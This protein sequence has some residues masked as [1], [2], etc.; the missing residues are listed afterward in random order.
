MTNA[1][2]TFERAE[3]YL[4]GLI[5]ERDSQRKSLG[6][7]RIRALLRALGDPHRSYPSVHVG[8]TSG[9]GSTATMIA[10]ALSAS[11]KRTGLH[12]KPHLHSM[13]ERAAIDGVSIERDRFGALLEE[14]LPAVERVT[15]AHGK[16]TYYETL[17]ALAFLYFAREGVDA[18]VIEVGLGGRL[19][20]TNVLLP[21]V[22]VI[23]S[24]GL[25]HTEVLG[26]TIEQ[27]AAEKAGIAK[28]GIPLVL[29]VEREEA[30]AVIE[31][32]AR[33]VGAPVIHAAR[34][35]E[36][37]PGEEERSFSVRTAQSGYELELSVYGSFQRGNARTAIVALEALPHS[38]RPSVE[39]VE[40]GLARVAIPGRMEIVN[41]DPPVV[42]DIAH[43]A[44]KAEH[45]ADALR[46]HFPGRTMHALV[47]IGEG[48][49]AA[50]ILQALAPL[51]SQVTVTSFEAAGRRPVAPSRLAELA[52]S[53]APARV[54]SRPDEAFA[55]ACEACAPGEV[56]LV[57]GSTFVVAAVRNDALARRARLVAQ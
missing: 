54:I 55:R 50:A 9:K 26:N 56:L 25:D 42:L 15:P 43:N 16:P 5:G 37:K 39:S 3:R 41:G 23:T 45:L 33:E 31:S 11:G 24:V 17:L 8:G 44:E 38:L 46:E 29:G 47:A 7:D 27:I 6:L 22:A 10:A 2:M 52:R 13:T 20:G 57:T 4:L 14:M 53:F 32:R 36:L 51:L 40:R 30:I 19:D 1:H 28:P 48:K 34:T 49:D 18:A 35:A 12:V 21:Q